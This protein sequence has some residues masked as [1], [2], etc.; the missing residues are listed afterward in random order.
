MASFTI[1]GVGTGTEQYII[2]QAV[3]KI[4]EAD[5]LIGGERNLIPWQ[6]NENKKYFIIKPPLEKVVTWIKEYYQNYKV[7]VLVSGD[8]GFYSL[9]NYLAQYFKK[10]EIQVIPGISS[11]QMAFARLALSWHDAVLLNLHGR[12]LETLDKY[13]NY[14]KI[15]LLTDPENNPRQIYQYLKEK[16]RYKGT[17]HICT[18][19]GYPDEAVQ[20]MQLTEPFTLTISDV[21]PTVMVILNE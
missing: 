7:V 14:S 15:A 8:P 19:L 18:N 2:P 17:I 16:G 11:I 13:I 9:L 20:T 10:E 4:K 12:S 6:G 3:N 21:K 5:V 1:V